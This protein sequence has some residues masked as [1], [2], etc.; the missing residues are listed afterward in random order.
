MKD[1]E[2]LDNLKFKVSYGSQG[3]D[4][5]L[6]NGVRNRYAYMDQFSV[7]N[8]NGQPAITQTYKGNDKLKWETNYNFNTGIE[9]SV[10]NGRLSGG[11]EFFSRY[12]KDLLFNRPLAAS[13]GSNSY[14]DNI[15][16]M[17]NTGFEVELSG[18]IIRTSK[19]N[20]NIS[21]NLS[22]IHI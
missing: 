22:L 10:L 7:S 19:I 8:N 16:D 6:L 20:W 2:W 12:A 4:Y 13:T 3:N 18:D 9:F 17:R 15:G 21:V 14:P 5:L 11:F 1:V